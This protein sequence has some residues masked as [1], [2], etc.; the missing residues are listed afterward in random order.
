MVYL[1]WEHFNRKKGRFCVVKAD[2]GGGSRNEEISMECDYN[3]MLKKCK[4]L[5]W[6]NRKKYAFGTTNDTNFYLVDFQRE[7]ICKLQ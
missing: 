7:P 6:E 2:K 3:E 4:E 5:F 1:S